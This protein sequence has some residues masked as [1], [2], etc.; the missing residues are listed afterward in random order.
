MDSKDISTSL[1]DKLV[2][3]FGF[4]NSE[5]KPTPSFLEIEN[6]YL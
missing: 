6:P 2:F 3:S 5:A 4:V 1:S